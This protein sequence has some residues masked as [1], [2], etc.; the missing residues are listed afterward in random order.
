MPRDHSGSEF[1]RLAATLNEM[2]DRIGELMDNLRQVSNDVAHDLRTPLARMQQALHAALAGDDD[3]ARLRA[4]AEAAAARS[5][6]LLELFAALLRIS[7]IE[8]LRVRAGFRAVDL[9]GL[10]EEVADTLR[11]EFEDAAHGLRCTIAAGIVVDGDRRLLAQLLVNLLENTL[12]HTPAGT[13]VRLELSRAHGVFE[14]HITDDGPGIASGDRDAVLR[15]FTRLEHSRSTPGHGL[16][17]SLV[18]AICKAHQF[19]LL[20]GEAS[21]GLRVTITGP[22]RAD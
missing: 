3:P 8:S 5:Q 19:S 9:S 7:E 2:L 10:A 14:L 22:A 21:P 1:D 17:L 13:C 6:E 12:R 18:A 4:A 15:R 16:G 11:P 20:L